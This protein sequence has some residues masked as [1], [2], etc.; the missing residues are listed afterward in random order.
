MQTKQVIQTLCFQNK[1]ALE[2]GK[3]DVS[4]ITCAY[5]AEARLDAFFFYVEALRPSCRWEV[6][7]IDNRSTDRTRAMMQDFAR[8]VPFP[9]RV[10]RADQPGAGA[11]RNEGMQHARGEVFC[12]TDDDCY[13]G[14]D[15]LDVGMRVF[16]DPGVGYAGGRILL[17]DP[18]DYPL[19]V[20]YQTVPESWG[21]DRLLRPGMIQGANMMFRASALRKVGGFD[22]D[23][24]AG[25]PYTCEELEPVIRMQADGWIGRH[26]PEAVVQHHH[27]RK[28]ADALKLNRNYQI[29]TG[30]CYAK[31]L[32]TLRPR[33]PTL[34]NWLGWQKYYMQIGKF[35]DVAMQWNGFFS[36]LFR[37]KAKG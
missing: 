25:A 21:H 3:I 7:L 16:Q 22:P 31:I 20:N 35:S 4:L 15:L 36:Y 14:P 23:F 6:V 17:Y 2:E 27:G 29:G 28:Q 26:V 10:V 37:R 33:W 8:R 30:A 34:R 9:V 12:F 19:T 24:G 13:V 18:E 1:A 32:C 11:A 5:N